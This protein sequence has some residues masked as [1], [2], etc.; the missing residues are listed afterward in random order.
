MPEELQRLEGGSESEKPVQTDS[1]YLA[2]SIPSTSRE[3]HAMERKHSFPLK[4]HQENMAVALVET[5]PFAM[6]DLNG[7]AC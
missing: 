3:A 5:D 7:C 1:D 6:T 4:S 2:P